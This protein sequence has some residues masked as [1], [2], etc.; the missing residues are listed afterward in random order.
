M[1]ASPKPAPH[2]QAEPAPGTAPKAASARPGGEVQRPPMPR[3]KSQSESAWGILLLCR[4]WLRYAESATYRD[5]ACCPPLP[6]TERHGRSIALEESRIAPSLAIPALDTPPPATPSKPRI[7]PPMHRDAAPAYAPCGPPTKYSPPLPLPKQ[8][9]RR[10]APASSCWAVPGWGGVGRVAVPPR[11]PKNGVSGTEQPEIPRHARR[12]EVVRGGGETPARAASVTSAIE[13]MAG[14]AGG[15][16]PSTGMLGA[17][18]RSRSLDWPEDGGWVRWPDGM[19]AGAGL[20]GGW[21]AGAW[22]AGCGADEPGGWC[23][24]G[25]CVGGG[26]GGGSV[27]GLSTSCCACPPLARDRSSANCSCGR[28]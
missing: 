8:L 23:V 10:T 25:W 6:S 16:S 18:G 12:G 14:G 5:C 13:G 21:P 26:S 17:G 27:G 15:Q 4:L 24:G 11:V 9:P 1:H 2:T 22:S 19:K 20:A 7:A 3:L 28:P